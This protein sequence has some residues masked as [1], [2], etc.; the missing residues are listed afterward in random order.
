M[1]NFSFITDLI[2]RA[3]LDRTFDHILDLLTLSESDPYKDKKI[4]ASSLRKTIVIHTASI[5]EALLLWK[6]K[7]ELKNKRV[8]L[9]DE[10][11]YFNIKVIHKFSESEEI[12]AGA[13]KKEVKKINQ[14][15]LIRITD[16]C[17]KYK[18]I[19][20]KLAKRVHQ[21]R[22]LR[23]RLHIG[24]LTAMEKEYTKKDLNF[25]FDVAKAV[26]RVVSKIY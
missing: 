15:D 10:W 20:N 11:K 6:L 25:V 9:G 12:I 23:N 22:E 4:L 24:G 19:N 17:K 5:I 2:L 21:L 14:L 7:Q 26:K 18:I 16:L 1:S 8:E 3:N 13:R